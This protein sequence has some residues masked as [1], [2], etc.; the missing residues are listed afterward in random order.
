MQTFN[1]YLM[2]AAILLVIICGCAIEASHQYGLA[3]DNRMIPLLVVLS[4]GMILGL[5]VVIQL[6][7]SL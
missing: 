4:A 3:H 5:I 2:G 6:A 1:I 7:F